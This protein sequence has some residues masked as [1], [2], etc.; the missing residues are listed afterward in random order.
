[1]ISPKAR[2]L[3]LPSHIIHALNGLVVGGNGVMLEQP[4]ILKKLGV[5]RSG[6][7]GRNHDRLLQCDGGAGLCSELWQ[8]V[9]FRSEK[10]EKSLR[11]DRSIRS[12]DASE[13]IIR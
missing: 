12:F 6:A 5:S 1:V 4:Q 11:L 13:T 3:L 10:F 7:N 8:I 9:P 2:D